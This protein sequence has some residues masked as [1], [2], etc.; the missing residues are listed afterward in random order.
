[1][2][3][4][5]LG[6]STQSS[7]TDLG[8]LAA[9]TNIIVQVL[10]GVLPK[11]FPTKLLTLIVGLIVSIVFS[12]LC[13]DNKINAAISGTI[14]GFIASFISMDGF[15]S[16]KSIYSRFKNITLE[17]NEDNTGGEG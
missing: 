14:I 13:Y 3:E 5:F 1:M 11:K 10:K 9:L 6:L 15:D 4:K 12:L 16:F 7:L 8:V 2:I 17:S